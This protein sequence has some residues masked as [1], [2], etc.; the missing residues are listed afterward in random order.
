MYVVVSIEPLMSFIYE[1]IRVYIKRYVSELE[2]T[3]CFLEQ[4]C[5][6]TKK[7]KVGIPNKTVQTLTTARRRSKQ[8]VRSHRCLPAARGQSRK[9]PKTRKLAESSNGA[10]HSVGNL[11]R[12]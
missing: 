6:S 11:A 12:C 4:Y 5:A 7:K 3:D 8:R 9:T 2:R 10:L 1:Y